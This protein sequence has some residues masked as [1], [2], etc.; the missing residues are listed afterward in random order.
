[1]A[2]AERQLQDLVSR[3]EIKRAAEGI[4][5]NPPGIILVLDNW[6]GKSPKKRSAALQTM[7]VR[8]AIA[9]AVHFS[10]QYKSSEQRPYVCSFAGEHIE[11][12]QAGSELV[13]KH[14]LAFGVPEDKIIARQTT[15]T[16]RGDISQ[17]HSLAKEKRLD[18]NTSLV[19]VTTNDHVK[20]TVQESINHFSAHRDTESI[21]T[22]Y[23]LAPSSP[24]TGEIW[25]KYASESQKPIIGEII[26]QGKSRKLSHGLSEVFAYHLSRGQHIRFIQP[27]AERIN[28]WY[29]PEE[30]Q[31]IGRTVRA[32]RRAAVRREKVHATSS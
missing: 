5:N 13:K 14:L 21:P 11:G 28:H 29:Q 25:S 9:A 8:A 2:Q 22:V 30:V 23:V 10:P 18:P 15:I 32:F 6:R 12:E 7:R 19:I 3:R 20:R 27:F 4:L 31:R 1:M 16:T 26:E 24:Q 17:L